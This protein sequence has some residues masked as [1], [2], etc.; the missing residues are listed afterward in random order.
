MMKMNT[1]RYHYGE[2][3][4]QKPVFVFVGAKKP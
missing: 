2:N 3:V 1:K 4:K